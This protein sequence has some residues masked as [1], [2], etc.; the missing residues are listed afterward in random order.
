[1]ISGSSAVLRFIS[2]CVT[3]RRLRRP[4]ELQKM[5][6]LP[7]NRLEPA[8]PFSYST[9]DFF[10][11]FIIKERRSD[12]KCYGQLRS[13][14]GA[15]FMGAQ[16]KLKTAM[17]EMD[18]DHVHECFLRNGCQWIPFKMNVPHSSHMG[19]CWEWLICSVHNA[20]EPLLLK[21]GSQLDDETLRTFITEVECII[22]SRPFSVD[23]ICNV[24]APG[25]LTP[26]HLLTMKAK[27]VLPPPRE[28]QRGDI[29]SHR[30][31]R[32]L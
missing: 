23:H 29:Y 12:V 27:R 2:S 21:A 24:E 25:P 26:N 30:C 5:A 28:F 8:L 3:C 9:T 13:D 4:T 31:W 20:F 17:S 32:R 11:P 19:G 1:M 6:F 18:K 22:N 15:N 14:Q 16:N 10:G 7:D